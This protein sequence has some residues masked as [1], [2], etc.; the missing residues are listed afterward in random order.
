MLSKDG[1]RGVGKD[2]GVLVWDRQEPVNLSI[3][4]SSE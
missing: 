4:I 2:M 3:Y 1:D